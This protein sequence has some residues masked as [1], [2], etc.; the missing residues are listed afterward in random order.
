MVFKYDVVFLIFFFC[1]GNDVVGYDL[2]YD[3]V[4]ISGGGDCFIC[5][6]FFDVGMGFFVR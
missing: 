3:G 4:N 5:F 2:V 6:E 1:L